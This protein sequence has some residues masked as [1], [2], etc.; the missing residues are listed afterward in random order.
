MMN[1]IRIKA[2]ALAF[3]LFPISGNADGV[4]TLSEKSIPELRQ[5]KQAI[6]EELGEL[7]AYSLR[8][9][10][11]TIGYRSDDRKSPDNTEW[12][13]INLDKEQQIDLIVL[14]PSIWR[15]AITGFHAEAFPVNFN[16]TLGTASETN[17]TQVAS[18]SAADHL[19][20]RIAPLVIPVEKTKASWVRLTCTR[21]SQRSFD[22]IYCME[23]SEIM[24]FS[25]SDNVAL[26]QNVT[27]SS[28]REG[29]PRSTSYAVDGF[30]PYIMNTSRGKHSLALI[31][32][33]RPNET[34]S[35]TIDL[36]TPRALDW[37]HLHAV[38][39]SDTVPQ[40]FVGAL[41]MPRRMT[42]E[43]ANLPD[44]SDARMIIETTTPT[45]YDTGPILMEQLPETT[46]RYVRFTAIE[47]YIQQTKNAVPRFGFAEIE[48]F[49]SGINVALNKSTTATF[50]VRNPVR[51][52]SAL[53]DG[54][55]LYGEI[56]PIRDWMQELARRHALENELPL[57]TE[58]LNERYA[59][60]NAKVKMLSS[61]IIW[62]LSVIGLIILVDQLLRMRY[63]AKIKERFAT[64][65]HDELGA[66][67]HAIGILG[68]H[69]IDILD[70]REKLIRTVKEIKSLTDRTGEATRYC[71]SVQ[72]AKEIHADL[73]VDLKRTAQRIIAN[74]DYSLHIEGEELIKNLKPRKRTDLFLF[75]KESL[76]NI[77]RHADATEVQIQLVAKNNQLEL[78][79]SDNGHGLIGDTPSSLKRRAR[80]L[81]G[82]VSTTETETGGTCITLQLRLRKIGFRKRAS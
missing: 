73:P 8:S 79:I 23:L 9:G 58:A 30:T 76:V 70:S 60:Q 75:F 78:T 74:L 71:T 32:S 57:I 54:H 38:E 34:A 18:F 77:N 46:C 40:S 62:L 15:Q 72:T 10:T 50:N 12:I 29:D 56:I 2:I 55:N 16:I 17:G 28:S 51:S 19:L 22:Q 25:G 64:D 80:L 39:Q 35:L 63:V 33:L 52:F 82:K 20:P 6:E 7:S 24:I 37:L 66:N 26:H 36:E 68:T 81:G 53:T 59:K 5:Q 48:L 13:Q 3:I 31:T 49:S 67:L 4:P 42:V 11:G 41:G 69:I 1:L 65:L 61:I 14:V 44:F 43:G 27:A 21:L 45:V 47:P